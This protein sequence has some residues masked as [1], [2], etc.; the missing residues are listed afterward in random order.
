M[1]FA[2]VRLVGLA[3]MLASTIVIASFALFALNQTSS[4]SAHQQQSLGGAVAATEPG[5]AA[6]RAAASPRKSPVHQAIDDAS[7]WLTSPFAGLTSG[8]HSEWTIRSVGLLL[9]LVLYGFGLGF[10]ARVLRVRT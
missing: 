5:A 6:P 8:S 2:I 7:E 1:Y 10:V 4:A 9:S 3:S